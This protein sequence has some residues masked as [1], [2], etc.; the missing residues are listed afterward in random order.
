MTSTTVT[1]YRRKRASRIPAG[2]RA[3]KGGLW[4][5]T[6]GADRPRLTTTLPVETLDQLDALAERHQLQRNEVLTLALAVLAHPVHAHP[7]AA[8]RFQ[9]LAAAWEGFATGV[10]APAAPEPSP[11]PEPVR[12]GN[13]RPGKL[14]AAAKARISEHLDLGTAAPRGWMT[15][16]AKELGCTAGAISRAA[17]KLR[18]AAPAEPAPARAPLTI[19]MADVYDTLRHTL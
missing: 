16:L 4:V 17:S 6:G 13:T 18:A 2:N 19:D 10:R 1:D 9:G 5:G 3:S 8:L 12:T 11:T 14:G 7:Q 15:A